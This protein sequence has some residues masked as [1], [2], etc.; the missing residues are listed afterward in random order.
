[1]RRIM[2]RT[3]LPGSGLRRV[4]FLKGEERLEDGKDP[5]DSLIRREVV[6]RIDTA[7]AE[8]IAQAAPEQIVV[9]TSGG[10]PAVNNLVEEVVRLYAAG[11]RVQVRSLEISDGARAIPPS[12]D[13]AVERQR[14]PD[15]LTSYQARRY[16]IDLVEQGNLIAAWGA[17]RHLHADQFERR[18]TRVMEWAYCFA[19]SLPLPEE[20]D[21]DALGHQSM[22]ARAALRVD[23]ALRA[24][25]I[26]RAAHGTYAFFECVLWEH[27]GQYVGDRHPEEKRWYQVRKPAPPDLVRSPGATDNA[28]RPFKE[29]RDS[30]EYYEVFDRIECAKLFANY[31][32]LEGLR[33]LCEAISQVRYLRNDIAHNEPTPELMAEARR[34]MEQMG[35]WS[36]DGRFLAQP[37]IQGALHELR[38][39]T[40]DRLCEKFLQEIRCRLQAGD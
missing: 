6:R 38:V 25:D 20:C 5:R 1:M 7:V 4:S 22:A 21:I 14:V 30:A 39:C 8:S 34:T 27:Y 2:E 37:L 18:W 19:A 17:V 23:L 24:N 11:M 33:K 12:R 40:T 15:P 32:K 35:L 13:R 29:A 10:F 9:A 26:P 28:C 36:T 16:A 3:S 31:H